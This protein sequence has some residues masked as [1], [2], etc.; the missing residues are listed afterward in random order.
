MK[1]GLSY[2][3]QI[4][5]G[6]PTNVGGWVAQTFNQLAASIGTGY[7]TEHQDD[8]T[9]GNVHAL[10]LTMSAQ[11]RCAVYASA[12]QSIGT[13]LY[14]VLTFNV[15]EYNIGPLHTTASNISRLTVPAGAAG[16]YLFQ[17]GTSWEANA[18]GQRAVKVV[19]NGT[20]DVPGGGAVVGVPAAAYTTQTTTQMMFLPLLAGDYLEVFVYQDSGGNLLA[21]SITPP[22]AS[23]ARFMKLW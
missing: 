23:F 9:H 14:T 17:A 6:D 18:A 10:T 1:I 7:H 20:I 11:P 4:R 8:D 13:A 3:T 12:Q 21:G 15:D 5:S 16:N 22:F 19:K 2:I